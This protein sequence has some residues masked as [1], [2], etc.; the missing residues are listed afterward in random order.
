LPVAQFA[1]FIKQAAVM[2]ILIGKSG[3]APPNYY[4]VLFSSRAG[5]AVFKPVSFGCGN[6]KSGY[7]SS[8]LQRFIF[9]VFA[10]IFY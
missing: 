8:I 4:R 6:G 3:K 9:R 1:L 5:L 2:N 10:C 7:G